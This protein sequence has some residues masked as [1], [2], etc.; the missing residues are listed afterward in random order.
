[1]VE[2]LLTL[3]GIVVGAIVA[4]IGT[5]VHA[6]IMI[7]LL[8]FA[9]LRGRKK[10]RTVT[11][12]QNQ[13]APTVNSAVEGEPMPTAEDFKQE[14]QRLMLEAQNAGKEFVVINAGEL[15]RRV[16]GYPGINHRMPNCCQVMR[17]QTLDSADMVVDAPPSGLGATLTIRYRLP[18]RDWV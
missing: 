1:M 5:V 7:F 17:A 13:P 6:V 18:R 2:L 4:V 16:G 11:V 14:L 12:A 3:I 10:S 15:H 8:P 9:F